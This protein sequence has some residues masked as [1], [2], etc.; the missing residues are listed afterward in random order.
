MANLTDRLLPGPDDPKEVSPDVPFEIAKHDFAAAMGE[1][2][3]G[4]I[5]RQNVIDAFGL[6][7]NAITDLDALIDFVQGLPNTTQRKLFIWDLHNVLLLSEAGLAYTTRAQ[8][9]TRLGI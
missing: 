1:F 7:T 3:G 2:E 6:E 5:T 9:R 8:L 4:Y